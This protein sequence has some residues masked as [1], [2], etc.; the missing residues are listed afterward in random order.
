MRSLWTITIPAEVF[1][2]V[3]FSTKRS[4]VRTSPTMPQRESAPTGAAFEKTPSPV[5]L[6]RNQQMRLGPYSVCTQLSVVMFQ[7][8]PVVRNRSSP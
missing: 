4:V 2:L 6:S 7:S 3:R 1:E 5:S 8:T